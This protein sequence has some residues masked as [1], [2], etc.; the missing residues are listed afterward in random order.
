VKPFKMASKEAIASKLGELPVR[1]PTLKPHL[2]PHAYSTR[3]L[4]PGWILEKTSCSATENSPH[5]SGS[6]LS[7]KTVGS[8]LCVYS[9][10]MY[11]LLRCR[12]RYFS[13]GLALGSEGFVDRIFHAKLSDPARIARSCPAFNRRAGQLVCPRRLCIPAVSFSGLLAA[14]GSP[15]ALTQPHALAPH[16]L[17]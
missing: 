4:A 13:D 6:A 12:V 17:P 9:G 15:M 10:A 14:S 1:K 2:K 7:G 16:C 8:F 3:L 5:K 11:E